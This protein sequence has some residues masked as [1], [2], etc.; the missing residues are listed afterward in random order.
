M[1][2][3]VYCGKDIL[4]TKQLDFCSEYCRDKWEKQFERKGE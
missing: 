4:T 1:T 2:N 3:C